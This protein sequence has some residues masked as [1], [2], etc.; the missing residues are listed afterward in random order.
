MTGTRETVAVV[1][2]EG[3]ATGT[4][5]EVADAHGLRLRVT[6]VTD[7]LPAPDGLELAI[8]MGSPE[9]AYDDTLPWLARER[10]WLREVIAH[11]VPVLGICFGSQLLARELGGGAYR[12][13]ELEA[14][15]VSV[16]TRAPELVPEGPWL[17]FHFD[18]FRVPPAARLLADTE[19]APQA[20]AQ[21]RCA[22]V[23]FHPEIT[24]EMFDAWLDDWRSSPEGHRM[25]DDLGD[26]PEALR[27]RIGQEQPAARERFERLMGNMLAEIM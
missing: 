14:G 19:L 23:Q 9:A 24:V 21:A 17:N 15:W 10:A 2:A 26:M 12:N 22:G 18:A 16:D 20:F 6:P 13:H 4:L 3:D 1:H 7:E 8:V 5:P 11:G 25:L 27:E